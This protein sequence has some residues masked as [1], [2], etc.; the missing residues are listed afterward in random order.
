[1]HKIRFMCE[2]PCAFCI[3]VRLILVQF[4]SG[5]GCR[6][7][8]VFLYFRHV[9]LHTVYTGSGGNESKRHKTVVETLR[10]PNPSSLTQFLHTKFLYHSGVSPDFV[11]SGRRATVVWGPECTVVRSRHYC[12]LTQGLLEFH[13]VHKMFLF[14][15]IRFVRVL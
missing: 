12:D 10:R 3:R 11:P 9:S 7:L 13:S 1:M 5:A 8:F 6:S 2:D 14:T 15:R 4:G